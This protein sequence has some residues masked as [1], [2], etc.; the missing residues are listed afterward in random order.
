MNG[1]AIAPGLVI[2]AVALVLS[3]SS[4]KRVLGWGV[5]A[6]VG[7]ALVVAAA[8][9][10]PALAQP[11]LVGCWISVLAAAACVHL[12]R[13]SGPFV[14]TILGLNGGIWAGLVVATSG[15][16]ADLRW[17]L[18]WALLAFPGGWIVR[19]GW[20]LGI[21]VAVSWLAATAVLSLG[22]NM[23]PTLGYEPDHME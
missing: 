21:K 15:Q 13:G 4:T 8:P 10:G 11:V 1:S 3:F 12:P 22:L 20:G 18:P 5:A 2:A 23:A 6:L 9:I 16:M 7:S 19:R 14:A 17:A